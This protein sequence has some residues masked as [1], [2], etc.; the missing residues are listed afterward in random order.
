MQNFIKYNKSCRIWLSAFL[1]CIMAIGIIPIPVFAEGTESAQNDPHP[2]IGKVFDIAY[3]EVPYIWSG[4]EDVIAI[5]PH[6]VQDSEDPSWTRVVYYVDHPDRASSPWASWN[7]ANRGPISARRY[8]TT[9]LGNVHVEIYCADPHLPGPGAG[10]IYAIYDRW[11]NAPQMIVNALRY[12]YP[13]NTSHL[14]NATDPNPNHSLA[15]VSYLTRVAVALAFAGGIGTLEGDEGIAQ[16]AHNLVN[17]N[18]PHGFNPANQISINGQQD[19]IAQGIS[20]GG[21]IVGAFDLVCENT[22]HS[23]LSHREN[24][25]M[26]S[27]AAGTPAGTQLRGPFGT[28]T[29]PALPNPNRFEGHMTFQIAV[30]EGQNAENA[31]INVQGLNN[32]SAGVWRATRVIDGTPTSPGTG[33]YQTMV[34][35][36]PLV[37]ASA[38]L[39]ADT[40]EAGLRIIKRNPSGQGLAGAVF[41]ITGPNGFSQTITTPANGVILLNSLEPGEYTITETSPPPG[42]QLASPATVTVTIPPGSTEVIERIFINPPYT[43][44]EP[45]PR[46]APPPPVRIQKI[47][48]LTRE[49]IPGA[50]MRIEGRSSFQ[51]VTGD[52]QLWEIDN[53]GIDISVVLTEGHTLPVVPEASEDGPPPVEFDLQDGV[54]T[55]YNLPWGYYRV[56]EERAPDGYSLLPQHT[57]Y[58]FWVLPPNIFVDVAENGGSGGSEDAEEGSVEAML[59]AVANNE[60]G[61]PADGQEPDPDGDS[62]G[63][64]FI[65][66]EE[67][68]VNSIL[69]TFENYPFGE[70]IVYKHS[71]ADNSPLAGAHIRIQGFFVEGNAPVITDR[72]YVTDSNGRVVFGDLP[73]G[74]YT[75]T[76][77]QAP[78]GYMLAEINHHSVNLSWGQRESNP[79]RPAP[80]VRF[81]NEPYTYLEVLKIDGNTNAPLPGAIFMLSDPTTGEEWLGTT[82][83][84]GR[85]IIGQEG[86]NFLI[87]GRTYILREVQA[88]TEPRQYVLNSYPR[89]IVLS[90]RGRNE[91]VIAN[92]H[93]PSLTIIKRD[94]DTQA[95]LA[96]AV[97]EVVFENGQTVAGSPF[98]T[99]NNGR[100]IIPEILFPDNPERTLI[101]TEIVPPPGYNLADPNWQ[102]VVMR[103]G[104]DNVIV[105][106]NR[107][108]PTLTIQKIDARTGYPIQGAWFYIEYLGATAGTGSGNI[109]PSGPLTGNPFVTDQNGRIII[110]G[111]YSGRYRIREVR[112]ADNY[113][114]TPLEADRTWIIEV[115][116]NEDYTLVVENTLLP[117]LVITKRNALT[118]RPI[119]M[120]QFRVD[121]EVPNSPHVQHIG[122]FMTNQQGQ[123]IL[124]FVQV[125]WYRVQ[126][127]RPAFGMTLATNNHF[128][129]FLQPGDN[130]YALISEGIIASDSMIVPAT[131]NTTP[132]TIG[133]EPVFEADDSTNE[134]LEN[135]NS[136]I[137]NAPTP[138][139]PA[140][141]EI[142]AIAP[143]MDAIVENNLAPETSDPTGNI[144]TNFPDDFFYE[145]DLENIEITLY[146]DPALM[147][148]LSGQMQVWGGDQFWNNEL[149]VWNF[150]Q[151]S[152]IIRKE[153]ATTGQLLQGATFSVT[154]ISSGND[155]GLAGTII[156]HFTTNHSGIIVISGL[157]PGYFVVEE[158]VP[159]PN[160]ALSTNN[161]Q[162]AFLRPDGTSIVE[163]TFSNLPY[164]SLIITLRCSVTS[165]PIP[166][167]E[168]RITNSAGAVVGT[169]NGHFWTNLQGEILISN[170]VPDSYIITQVTVPPQFVINLVQSTQTI[171]V[172]PTGQIYRVDFFSDPLSNL[173]ITLRCEVS[174]QPIQGGEFRVT[175]SAGNVVGS[176]NGIFFTD[177]QGEILIPGLGVDSYVV[178]QLNAP[179][180][181]RL[182]EQNSQTIFIQRPAETY[183]LN[184]TNEPYSGLIIQNLDGYNG[185]PLPGVRFR[186]DRIDDTGNVLIGEHVT[187]SN[188]RIEL[189]GLLG[190]FNIT[191]LDVPNGWEFDAQPIRIAHVNTGAPTL[192]TFH[193]PRM[194]SLEITL[195]DEDGLPLAGGRFEVRRQ[196]GQIVGEFVT[197]VS[198]MVSI[199]NL[200]SGW[201]T[202]EQMAP[203][204]GFVMTDTGRSV[205]VSTNTVARANFINIQQPSLVIEKVC[206]DGEPLAGAE[207]EVRTLSGTLVHRGVTN[208]G[209]IISIA[210]LEPGAFTITETRAPAGFVITEPSRTIEIVAGQ[211]LTTR[212]INHRS[213]ALIIE[214]VCENGEPLAGAEFEVRRLNGELVHRVVTNNGG[215]AI[216]DELAPGAYELIETRP[217]E[218]FAVV[219]PSRAIQ[220]V[221][222]ETRVERFV[223]PRLPTFVI[224]KIDGVTGQPLQGVIFEISTLAGERVRNP[225][226]G[227]FEF[228]TDNAGL[229]RLPMLDAGS[230]V[231]TET[232]A[233]PGYELAL[234]VT[235][236]VGYDRD[237]IITIRNYPLPD[238]NILKIDGHTLEPLAGVQFEVARFFANGS[239]GERLRNPVDGSFVWTTDRAGLI[240]LPNLEHGTYVA[241][242]IRPLPGYMLAEPKIFVVGDN[243]PTTLTIRNYRYSMWNI[244]KLDG[245]TNQPLAGVVFEIAHFYG[246]GTTGERLRNDTGSFEFVTDSAGIARI[247]TLEPGTYVV[248]ELRPLPGFVA[249]EPIIVTVRGNE[250]DTTITVRNYR[251]AELTIRKINSITRAPLAGVVF[252]ISRPD[253]TRLINPTTGFHDF[254]TDDRGLI[255]LPVM[256]DGRFYLRETRALPGFMID[257]EVIA[258]NIDAS[259]RQRDHVLTVE[260][261]PAA[262]LLI[263]KTDAQT[264]R[265]L[266]GVEF[267]IRH[268]DGRQ[269]TGQMLDGNQP[270]SPS[271]SPQLAANGNFLTDSQGRINLNHLAPGVYHVVET[272]ALPGYQLDSTVHVVTVIAGQQTVL[273]V[274]NAPLAGFRLLKIDA[275]TGEPIYNVEF[276]VFDH[277]GKVVGVFYTDNN[278]LIDFSAILAPGRYTIRETRPAPGYAR[279]DVPR[280]VEF[281]AGRVTEIVWENIPI[282]GQL[283]ILKVSGD[284]NQHNGLPAGTPLAGAIFEIYDART[285]NLVDRIISNDRGMAVSRPLPLGRYIAREVAAPDFFM[286]N[287]QEIPFEIEFENQI[288]RVQFPNF[289]ANMGVTIRKVGPQ[290]AMQGHNIFYDIMTVRNDSTVP[291]SDFFWR[292]V[293]PTNAVRADR[294]VTG[295]YNAALRYRVMATTNRG[296]EIVVADNLSTTTNNVIELGPVHLRLG[297]DEYIV[298]FTLFFGQVP[299]GFMSVERP[300]IYVNVLSANQTLL[301]DGLLFA[302]KVDVGGRVV[303]SNEWVI[304]NSTTATRIFNPSR[305][306]QSGW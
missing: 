177:L 184:F 204:Q 101:V 25:Y 44:G 141:V 121:F 108:M 46:I 220:I 249:A 152:L 266:A 45:E 219:E 140:D 54:L 301:P 70:I 118:W 257:Q 81:Y 282:A 176:A 110:E 270:G 159:P 291:L 129:V 148:R 58:S 153:D 230:Y 179:D 298:E 222:G 104:E 130:S 236:I 216:I 23:H 102:R 286:I 21:F 149:G 19:G 300:R 241:T 262:G 89:E 288:V 256:E 116:D 259:A 91:V 244:L 193:S 198:G 117:T 305:I 190:S 146:D 137:S 251:M 242:E 93:N 189:T 302:N 223:N 80:V 36:I 161:R 8:H 209:G 195:S 48:A 199:P 299:A 268:A 237:Y 30:P 267:E 234:P 208:N 255:F 263:I 105:F 201:F 214:K 77:I 126:E 11:H 218:G 4:E 56:Q 1:T 239:V 277:N 297:A 172:N 274:V 75:I 107:R 52:G 197:P 276:M 34:F 132:P 233:L 279:D 246:T 203:P 87:P 127:T 142:E 12:G 156:G 169:D 7:S 76:E 64:E 98:T 120:T 28:V 275:I 72:T 151:N 18:P 154:Q 303:G 114:L 20:E 238:Y 296:H 67:E 187:D 205:E 95:Y 9:A 180:G 78:P 166:D 304:G 165:A 283:Q 59:Y 231:A 207:F 84:D 26:F 213:P 17:G 186:I 83:A 15:Y 47:D 85:V 287:P 162:H 43:N 289:S 232:M 134:L 144:Y 160:F 139:I 138:D 243:E 51:M 164:G 32:D 194:G 22:N 170:V 99:D 173:L 181:F 192:V 183:A 264:G 281:V 111:V 41:Q 175:N 62:G 106:E 57:A 292:D 221:A 158:T 136:D 271:N 74:T 10:R 53:R 125:G 265:P 171:R 60:L 128:R 253:G 119:P 131:T 65:I 35:Y 113:W 248:T 133:E 33:D 261:T 272:R 178:T 285:G 115:R 245:D 6:I 13:N 182:G 37:E 145:I 185:D 306:P 5:A 226:N 97:F 68:S 254:I 258:F 269:V 200:G 224:N 147:S 290:E 40:P 135:G 295:T 103:E 31:G 217:P 42:H 202:V 14:D 174:G 293:L 96:G 38:R 280:T 206:T 225:V 39:T 55:I 61:G 29:F 212:F 50:L 82:G 27:W 284:D 3:E 227:S 229:I 143:D 215:V 163:V 150:P 260:N 90:N 273:E 112:A 49:N 73:A 24:P 69:I 155:S 278:G 123:I 294:L 109:G 94:M 247:G 122:Y 79:A 211:T 2:W 16:H 235:F 100:I 252:E 228:V 66:D 210:R 124:P 240:R 88:P 167:A 86:N 92:Y 71:N 250:V 191:Q 188:G 63:V 196:N 157:D 168:F